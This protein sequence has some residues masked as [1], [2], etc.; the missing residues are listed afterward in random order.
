MKLMFD[1]IIIT[2]TAVTT[3]AQADV[4]RPAYCRPHT[5]WVTQQERAATATAPR[6]PTKTSVIRDPVQ[7]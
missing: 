4:S 7:R 5:S 2:T 6:P 3:S 1:W